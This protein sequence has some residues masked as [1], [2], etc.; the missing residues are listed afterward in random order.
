[1][2]QWLI[3]VRNDAFAVLGGNGIRVDQ[4]LSKARFGEYENRNKLKPMR[5][6]G[7]KEQ[8]PQLGQKKPGLKSRP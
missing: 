3:A 2:V 1:V 5:Q 8:F 4:L 6:N 7:L